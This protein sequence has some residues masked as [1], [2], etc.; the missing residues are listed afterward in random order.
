MGRGKRYDIVRSYNKLYPAPCE[1]TIP[2]TFKDKKG[3]TFGLPRSCFGK[4][5]LPTQQPID[6]LIPGPGAYATN[7]FIGKDS[8]KHSMR[9]KIGPSKFNLNVPGPGTYIP[10]TSINKEGKFIYSFYKNFPTAKFNPLSTSHDNKK[11]IFKIVVVPGPGTYSTE[12]IAFNPKINY[13]L[14]SYIN[15]G[16][17]SKTTTKREIFPES[18]ISKF[19]KKF[20]VLE[21]TYLILNLVLVVN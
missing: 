21:H 9:R 7:E 13:T 16:R 10:L 2:S 15:N 18:K 6:Y 14:S 4:V 8:T 1:Y 20:Q 19:Q 11:C 12:S 5:Y 3:Y 17:N